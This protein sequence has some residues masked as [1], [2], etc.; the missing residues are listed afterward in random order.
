MILKNGA[1]PFSLPLIPASYPNAHISI[2]L[3]CV[4][5]IAFLRSKRRDQEI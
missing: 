3:Q 2:D 1:I 5:K 4:L